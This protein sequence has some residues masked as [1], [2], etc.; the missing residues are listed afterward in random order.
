[1]LIGMSGGLSFFRNAEQVN[2]EHQI[3]T[4][5]SDSENHLH[6]SNTLHVSFTRVAISPDSDSHPVITT[7]SIPDAPGNEGAFFRG[8][9]SSVNPRG[10][11][12]IIC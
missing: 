9:R 6:H 2:P 4:Y 1:M 3:V 11:P 12:S 8:Y 10:P 5:Q 7:T